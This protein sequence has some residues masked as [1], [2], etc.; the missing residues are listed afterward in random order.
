MHTVS[1]LFYKIEIGGKGMK[2]W[3]HGIRWSADLETGYYAID[4]QHKELFNL[5][6]NLVEA[7]ES[8]KSLEILGD[9]L[10]FLASYTVKHFGDEEALQIKYNFPDYKRH[11]TLHDAFKAKALELIAQFKQ[12]GSCA[13]LRAQVNS[14]IVRWLLQHIR[15]EDFKVA[16]HIRTM[17]GTSK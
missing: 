9:T 5:T 11:K 13:T 14:V 1:A 6:S 12:D 3:A 15:G 17:T 8:D 2:E 4:S 7:C 10:N 16:E